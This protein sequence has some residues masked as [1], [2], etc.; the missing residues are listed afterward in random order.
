MKEPIITLDNEMHDRHELTQKAIQDSFY[1]GYLAKACLSSSAISQLLKSP[2]EYL[3]QINLPT[4]SDALA[5]GYLF[6][7]SILEEDKFN[8]CLFL[9]VKTKASKEYKCLIGFA[10]P[11]GINTTGVFNLIKNY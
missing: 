3:N 8:E 10:H 5:Q 1:Y 6:H 7:A 4:E 11:F 2:L 9:D